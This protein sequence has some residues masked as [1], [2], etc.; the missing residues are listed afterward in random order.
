[1]HIMFIDN[2]SHPFG[3]IMTSDITSGILGQGS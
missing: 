2:Y 3:V 1:M